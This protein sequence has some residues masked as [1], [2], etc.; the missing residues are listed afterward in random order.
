MLAHRIDDEADLIAKC[1]KILDMYVKWGARILFLV[2]VAVFGAW[3]LDE[4][5]ENALVT[6]ALV[7]FAL[8][9]MTHLTATVVITIIFLRP[10]MRVLGEGR[11]VAQHSEGFKHM[12]VTKRMTLVIIIT[13]VLVATYIYT[14]MHVGERKP[15]PSR[16][17]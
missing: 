4:S 11:G 7:V 14:C 8:I 5:S 3:I 16:T 1:L 6:P 12:Q 15:K 13:V 17:F 10:I 2:P 9:M